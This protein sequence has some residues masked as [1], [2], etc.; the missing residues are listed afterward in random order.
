VIGVE[1]GGVSHGGGNV[2]GQG[3]NYA[4]KRAEMWGEMRAWLKHGAIP[5]DAELA[6]DL[7]GPEYGFNGRDQI[8]LER[9][10][11]MKKRGLASPD[12]ADALALTFA[13]AAQ[14][15]GGGFGGGTPGKHE[16]DYDIFAD[17]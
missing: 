1:F 6:Q 8:Q 14:P 4:N 3:G 5:D 7:G 9:K 13:F 10:E 15:R 11:D 16:V 17:I 2:D 12:M